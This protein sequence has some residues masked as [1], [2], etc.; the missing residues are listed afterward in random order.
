MNALPGHIVAKQLALRPV[1]P[2]EGIPRTDSHVA[3]SLLARP[4]AIPRKGL[5][6]GL[7]KTDG[8]QQLHDRLRFCIACMALAH[9]GVMHQRVGASR[10]P[11]HGVA[12]EEHCRGCGATAPYRLNARLL[13]SPFRCAECRVPPALRGL[14]RQNGAASNAARTLPRDHAMTRAR[15]CG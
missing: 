5:A 4:F 11:W 6:D 2:Y 12:I 13:G 7:H 9:H 14:A 3:V 1:D 8:G 10:C 15:Y